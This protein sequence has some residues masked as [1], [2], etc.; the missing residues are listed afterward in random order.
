MPA[1]PS[2][3]VSGAADDPDIVVR[4]IRTKEHGA[5]VLV[6]NPSMKAKRGVAV[7][8]TAEGPVRDLVEKKIV[9]RESLRLDLPPGALRTFR[10]GGAP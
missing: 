1:L 8:F 7:R 4:E 2:A 5:W 3:V 10:V 6:V 9:D